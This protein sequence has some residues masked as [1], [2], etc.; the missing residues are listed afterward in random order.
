VWQA[1]GWWLL[2]FTFFG[3]RL[4]GSSSGTMTRRG[5]CWKADVTVTY[6]YCVCVCVFLIGGDTPEPTPRRKHRRSLSHSYSHRCKHARAH[7]RT[8]ARTHA[9]MHA[10]THA[11]TNTTRTHAFWL[12]RRRR[13]HYTTPHY[14]TTEFSFEKKK[15]VYPNWCGRFPRAGQR[16][17]SPPPR[18]HCT[19]QAPV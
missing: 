3:C 18:H 8:H 4:F 17:P 12:P 16:R 11:H 15:K 1:T 19:A 10:R 9:H 5:L 14:K 6:C 2:L 13:K 7:A